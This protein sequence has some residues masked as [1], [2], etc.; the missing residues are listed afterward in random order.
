MGIRTASW[1]F[2]DLEPGQY[3]VYATWPANPYLAA[4]HVPY[5]IFDDLTAVGTVL[6]S[7]RTVPSQVADA[8][9]YWD[10]IGDTV[11]IFGTSLTVEISNQAQGIVVADG[12]RLVHVSA[13]PVDAAPVIEKSVYYSES[14][15]RY[16]FRENP[17][18][19]SV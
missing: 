15:Q 6:V 7:Q 19:K 10:A 4:F 2:S 18:V 13:L 9:V 8:G 16:N 12:I 1:I 14:N 5:Q 3:Q 17:F 11:S